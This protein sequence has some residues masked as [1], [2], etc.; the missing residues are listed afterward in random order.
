M[1]ALKPGVVEECGG[2]VI[3][4][5]DLIR[6]HAVLDASGHL[7]GYRGSLQKAR[8]LARNIPSATWTPPP[9]PGRADRE[10]IM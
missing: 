5:D 10:T 6:K 7:H 9:P 2:G 4:W 3:V 1:E 8:E